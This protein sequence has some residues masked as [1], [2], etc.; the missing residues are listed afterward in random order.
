MGDAL[1]TQTQRL[2]ALLEPCL[3]VML[4]VFIGGLVMAILV[5]MITMSQQVS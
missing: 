5:P 1:E 2:L 4:A 3:I